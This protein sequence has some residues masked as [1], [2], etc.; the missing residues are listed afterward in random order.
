MRREDT[1]SADEF[2]VAG[3]GELHLAILVETL[4]R[5]GYEFSVSRPE[6]ITHE[7]DVRPW[8]GVKQQA[9]RAHASQAGGGADVRTVRLLAAL[10]RPLARRVLGRE[11]FVEVGAR[12]D[13]A[14]RVDPFIP[15]VR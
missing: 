4:R 8:V 9:L 7:V 2:L 5:E 14:R 13:A 3:R 11:W 12:A 6:V 10:P 15:A 1:E